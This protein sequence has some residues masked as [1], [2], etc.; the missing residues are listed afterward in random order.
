MNTKIIIYLFLQLDTLESRLYDF[1]LTEHVPSP[2]DYL[3]RICDRFGNFSYEIESMALFFLEISTT[4][5]AFVSVEPCVVAFSAVILAVFCNGFE[6]LPTFDTDY[7]S[8]EC[9]KLLWNITVQAT[10]EQKALSLIKE[11]YPAEVNKLSFVNVA[12]IESKLTC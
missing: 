7:I 6:N 4:S 10:R 11:R 12:N 1:S 3:K 8:F 2:V 5:Y 9:T